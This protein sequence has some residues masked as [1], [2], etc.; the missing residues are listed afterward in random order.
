MKDEQIKKIK[1]LLEDNKNHLDYSFLQGIIEKECTTNKDKEEFY[2]ILSSF[3]DENYKDSS[4]SL[5]DEIL[6]KLNAELDRLCLLANQT[7]YKTIL[8]AFNDLNRE[9]EKSFASG[10]DALKT[11]NVEL[12]YFHTPISIDVYRCFYSSDNEIIELPFDYPKFL[13]SY[14]KC[15]FYDN[16]YEEAISKLRQAMSYDRFYTDTYL[17][18]LK[19]DIILNNKLSIKNDLDLFYENFFDLS[20]YPEYIRTLE[21]YFLTDKS[22]NDLYAEFNR[23]KKINLGKYKNF[24]KL[25]DEKYKEK[26]KEQGIHLSLSTEMEKCILN[27]Y[28]KSIVDNNEN[29]LKYF[30]DILSID[31]DLKDKFD[32]DLKTGE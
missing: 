6:D 20:Y 5:E 22:L 4:S 27:I 29:K 23:V 13:N 24:D 3:L 7:N 15:L 12:C 31:L 16:R 11:S 9:I 21:T 2:D 1:K 10:F 26:L 32:I 14:S 25:I 8:P 30:S 17:N 19:Y 28:R 18:K